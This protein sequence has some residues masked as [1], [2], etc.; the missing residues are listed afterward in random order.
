MSTALIPPCDETAGRPARRA[1]PD[2]RGTLAATIAGSSL[3]FVMGSIVNVALPAMQ[4]SFGAGAT[5]AQWIVNAYL[6][7]L[8]ALVL[9][10]GALG[11]HY[12][13]RRVFQAGL[14]I[15]TVA[16]LLCALAPNFPILLAGRVLEGIG[17][18][19]VAPT[20]LAIIADGFSGAE[21]RRAVGTWAAAGAAAGALSPVLGGLIVDGPGWR[22]TF[23]AVIPL[24]LYAMLAAH[25]SV[26]ESRADRGERAPL[27]WAGASLAAGGLLALI[28]GLIALPDR[29]A[30]LPVTVALLAG[31]ALLAA[32]VALEWSKGDR[33]M[34]PLAL[35][36]QSTFSGLSLLTF[37]LYMALGG[38]L[39]LLP[40][41]LIRDIGY[42]ASLAGAAIL[43]FP[44]IMGL[45]S[46]SAGGALVDRFGTRSLLTAGSLLVAAGFLL[47]ARLPAEGAGYWRDI[48]PALVVLA[49]GMAASVAPLTAAV[50][51]SAGERYSGVASAV[52]NA[53][54]RVAGLIA[55]ALLGLVL[56]GSA[57]SLAAGFAQAALA[58]ALLS[59]LSAASA[60]LLVRAEV[61]EPTE[62]A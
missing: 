27:D 50:L 57:Q 48:F 21:R 40:Y 5:G 6:L 51:S 38:L 31:A 62:Q 36:A 49:L 55:T 13:R 56:L 58:G 25:R 19:L 3:A 23:A 17:G 41:V 26:R 12:G 45:L 8:G 52:N 60:F 24:A 2:Q 54:A 53:I 14:A 42:G 47:F 22:W 10:G 46:R 9:I 20:A 28:W 37:F 44:L 15:F 11:D 35:F 39:V 16:C 4:E 33:A 43:P 30:T 59:I 34:T 18:A 1:C 29:G 7:P 32:F 61:T